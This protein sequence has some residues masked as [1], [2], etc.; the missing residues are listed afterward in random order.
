MFPTLSQ[1]FT[2]SASKDLQSKVRPYSSVN[3]HPGSS[4]HSVGGEDGFN[5]GFVV[6]FVDG[7]KDGFV[8][9]TSDGIVEF[10]L[11]GFSDGKLLGSFDGFMDKV[12]GE[13]GIDEGFTEW[14]SPPPHSQHASVILLSLKYAS[15][16]V[17]RKLH[18]FSG[19]EF[20]SKQITSLYL[21]VPPTRQ[22]GSS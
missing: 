9:G 2:G 3:V 17:S 15:I 21:V 16:F 20:T 18:H 10:S 7:G 19:S 13:V 4:L 1:S 12:G 5:V 8:V 11:V 22:F 6:G 14:C